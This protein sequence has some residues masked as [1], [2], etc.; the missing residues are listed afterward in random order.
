[1]ICLKGVAAALALTL[2]RRLTAANFGK[3]TELKHRML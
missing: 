1:M 2:S 3:G